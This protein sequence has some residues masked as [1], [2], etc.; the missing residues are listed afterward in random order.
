MLVAVAIAIEEGV[1]R[2]DDLGGAILAIAA[3]LLLGLVGGHVIWGLTM[4]ALIPR[5]RHRWRIVVLT[6]GTPATIFVIGAAVG[7]AW[8]TGVTAV[9]VPAAFG[10][11]ASAPRPSMA[12]RPTQV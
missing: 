1:D 3:G 9:V 6:L 12:T 2:A 4:A 10:Y 5:P 11:W 8:W 7:P